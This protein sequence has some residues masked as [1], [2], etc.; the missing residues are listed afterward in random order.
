MRLHGQRPSKTS[1]GFVEPLQ[2]HQD[3]SL[4]VQRFSIR[5]G[6]L[7]TVPFLVP[8]SRDSI[9]TKM[10]RSHCALLPSSKGS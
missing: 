10:G 3:P 9:K 4:V 5:A 6:P 7:R 2:V 1:R 8:H